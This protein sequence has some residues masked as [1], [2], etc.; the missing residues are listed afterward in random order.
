MQTGHRPSGG[1]KQGR[2]HNV[3]V[4]TIWLGA[5]ASWNG[6]S[7][8]LPSRANFESGPQPVETIPSIPEKHLHYQVTVFPDTT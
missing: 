1:R 4:A 6:L 7:G 2:L 5:E 3:H 8:H